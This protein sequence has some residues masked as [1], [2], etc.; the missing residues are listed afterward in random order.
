MRRRKSGGTRSIVTRAAFLW[1]SG[2]LPLYV[3][4]LARHVEMC[5]SQRE[6]GSIMI[7]A[8]RRWRLRV[9]VRNQANERKNANE[10][11]F[12]S[13]GG[14]GAGTISNS[15]AATSSVTHKQLPNLY[16]SNRIKC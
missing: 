15:R 13:I 10:T 5:A 16:S 8:G 12:Q 1:R 14:E 6:R 2:E 7:E 3:T 11:G 4:G 9:C